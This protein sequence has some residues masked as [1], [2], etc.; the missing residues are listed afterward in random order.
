MRSFP[1]SSGFPDRPAGEPERGGGEDC[2]YGQVAAEDRG[3]GA[4]WQGAGPV[5]PE[6]HLLED[7]GVMDGL[8]RSYRLDR[9]CLEGQ[10][11]E[12]A[13]QEEQGN[14]Y[15]ADQDREDGP[16]LD[17]G[18]ERCS[19][20]DEHGEGEQGGPDDQAWVRGPRAVHGG[21][22]AQD[23]DGG[24]EGGDVGA[25]HLPGENRAAGRWGEQDFLDGA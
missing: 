6:R 8:G 12:H 15:A 10:R 4:E 9:R 21:D 18:A 1:R 17:G 20:R 2:E 25:G 16:V 7:D 14:G 11:A 22:D 5:S 24:G 3:V 13:A 19:R 23:D